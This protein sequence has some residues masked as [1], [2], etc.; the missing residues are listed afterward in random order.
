M[1]K[2]ALELSLK[3]EWTWHTG[4]WKKDTSDK[5]HSMTKVTE[6]GWLRTKGVKE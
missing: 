3:D 4:R 1:G 6:G 2:E 5:G